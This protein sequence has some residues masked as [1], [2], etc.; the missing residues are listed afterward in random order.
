MKICSV[1]ALVGFAISFALPI[2]A[3]EKEEVKP[4]FPSL[5]SLLVLN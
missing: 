5:L 4:P 1:A 3:Q 2:F